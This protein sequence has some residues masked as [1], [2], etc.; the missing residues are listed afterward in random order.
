MIKSSRLASDYH[1]QSK[2][3]QTWPW[4]QEKPAAP[5]GPHG[6]SSCFRSRPMCTFHA[7]LRGCTCM[8]CYRRAS[9]ALSA[10]TVWLESWGCSTI[11]L[12]LAA[13]SR[14]FLGSQTRE[15]WWKRRWFLH[16][17][18]C[19]HVVKWFNLWGSSVFVCKLEKILFSCALE[20]E[21]ELVR[22]WM[23][24]RVWGLRCY[25][26]IDRASIYIR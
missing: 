21:D 25:E 14:D 15:V 26:D 23:R 22:F 4:L 7:F 2:P 20:R 16:E 8:G 10:G 9:R 1:S 18:P 13:S 5:H 17:N 24:E 19:V 3:A 12:P 11:P 6:R